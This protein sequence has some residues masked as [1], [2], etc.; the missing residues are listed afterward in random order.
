MNY[1][2]NIM[3]LALFTTTLL[4]II[5]INSALYASSN[6]ANLSRRVDNAL[7]KYFNNHFSVTSSN[8]GIVTI[9]GTVNRLYYKYR[10]FEIAEKTKGVKGIRDLIAINT[11]PT[12]DDIIKANLLEDLRVDK[13]ILEP[14]R[15]K[16]AVSNG[17]IELNG[18]VSYPREKLLAE[19]LATWQKGA[20]GVV[21]QIKVLSPKAAESNRNMK[22]LLGDVLKYKF[23]LQRKDISFSVIHEHRCILGGAGDHTRLIEA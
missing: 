7:S 8:N 15:I 3:G 20:L 23:P 6:S 21:D 1:F 14:N 2:K 22:I 5:G 19:T 16:I 18:K 9:K 13:S 11:R 10:I 4:I 17:V 12:P